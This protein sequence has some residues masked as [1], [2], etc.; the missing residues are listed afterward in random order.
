MPPL[1]KRPVVLIVRDGWGHNP[2]PEM[3]AY[4]AVHLAKTPCDDELL[5]TYP[6]VQIKTSGEDVGL[7][8]GTMGNSE[9]GHQNIGAGRIVDQELMRINRTIRDKS[10]FQNPV[11]LGAFE[12]IQRTGGTLHLL[13]LL[14]D[15]GVHSHIDHALALVD[16]CQQ[17]GLAREKL[18][19]HVI[20]DGRD[21][22]PNGGIKFVATLENKLKESG[23]GS[24][25]S[26]IG[27]YYAMDRDYR[28]DRV[29][30]AYHLLTQGSTDAAPSATEALNQYYAHPTEPNRSGD[31]FVTPIS[32]S[33]AGH[34]LPGSLIKDGDAVI[35]Y[36]Y[37]GDRPRELTKAF[38]ASPEEWA[39]I[40][41]GGFP[42]PRP[43]QNLYFATLSSYEK[44]LNTRV[45]LDKPPK[46]TNILGDYLSS[47][48]LYQ[49]RC[50][51]SEKHPHVTYFFN[52]Y[53]EGGFPHELQLD[54]PSPKH[55]S[56]Y[57]QKPEM[58]APAVTHAVLN[59]IRSDIFDFILVNFANP[60]MVGHTGSLPAAIMAVETVDAGV[61]RLV[62]AALARGGALIITADHGNCEQ[63]FNPETGGPHT[64]HTTY[65][66]DLIVV[67]PDRKGA[68]LREGG[69]LGDI[70]PT[71]LELMG[72][73][74]PAEMTGRSL[75][76]T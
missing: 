58:S 1:K 59:A 51:E 43:L 41:G 13:G 60:D 37:R 18:A 54:I 23:V 71:V 68:H 28:W 7:P 74:I 67:D 21:T 24:I 61:A 33:P 14:S 26:V 31:E 29:E 65:D 45:V 44:G 20:T 72:L 53:R 16:L 48:G 70:A 66:V 19:V 76:K 42:R 39:R 12:H 15:G 69:R 56:T 6:N 34:T 36:N 52:D 2:H 35:F 75:L 3:N 57:D 30:K 32:I 46:M 22:A 62:E 64:Q 50:A 25:V 40:Q 38:V 9:V 27:R 17:R 73:P 10:L 8:A 55:V 47:Q 63:M 5:R 49:F 4:N 11:L